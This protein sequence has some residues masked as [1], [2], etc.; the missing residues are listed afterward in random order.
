MIFQVF[1]VGFDL[2]LNAFCF[3]LLAPHELP[4]GDDLAAHAVEQFADGID[5]HITLLVAVQGMADG[6]V[7]RQ[8]EEHGGVG[9]SNRG[10][11]GQR[12]QCL[13]ECHVGGRRQVG[14]LL[15][16]LA[17]HFGRGRLAAGLAELSQQPQQACQL[18]FL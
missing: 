15:L 18:F 2:Q 11:G 13:L 8:P 10:G 1:A 3:G 5:L 12:S 14:K 6:E 7:L 17:R 4:Q 9:A 16:D